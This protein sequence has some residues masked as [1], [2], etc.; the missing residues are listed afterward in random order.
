MTVSRLIHISANGTVSFVFMCISYF[1]SLSANPVRSFISVD[2]FFF[3][4]LVM[5]HIFLLLCKSNNFDCV[6]GSVN[7]VQCLDFVFCFQCV[8]NFALGGS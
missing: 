5:V 3:F 7:L 4:F 8:F 2:R 6:L 1:K